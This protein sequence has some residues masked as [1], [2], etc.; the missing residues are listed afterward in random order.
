MFAFALVNAILD[1]RSEDAVN[2]LAVMKFRRVD[3]VILM[4]EI[5]KTVCDMMAVKAMLNEG[6][7]ASEMAFLFNNSEYRAKIYAR[8]AARTSMERLR[9]AIELCDEADESVKFASQGYVAV[10]RLICSL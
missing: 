4:S 3:P 6:R 1:G 2:A 7:S 9:A 5:S 8:G 10:E